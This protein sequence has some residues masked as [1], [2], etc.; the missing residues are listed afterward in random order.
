MVEVFT[1][2][3][4]ADGGYTTVITRREGRIRMMFNRQF[5]GK[6]GMDKANA[7]TPETVLW[8]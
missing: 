6:I 3:L 8:G 1:I 5:L 2:A 4:G 7:D